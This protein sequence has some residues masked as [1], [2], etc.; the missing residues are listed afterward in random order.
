MNQAGIRAE[1]AVVVDRPPATVHEFVVVRFFDNYPRWS[2]EVVE[3][4]ALDAGPVAEGTRG[5]QVR[6][7]H[8]RRSETRFRVTGLEPGRGARFEGGRSPGFCIRYDFEP[9][10]DGRTRLSLTFDLERLTLVMRPFAG[11]IR[12]AIDEGTERAVDNIKALVERE[13]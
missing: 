7:D 5:R 13:Y 2:P 9:L 3:L 4:E 1:A 10:G 6:I 12:R 11:L 8:G